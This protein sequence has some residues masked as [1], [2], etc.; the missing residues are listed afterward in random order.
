MTED[1]FLK[2]H[3]LPLMLPG[4]V[5]IA[6]LIVSDWTPDRRIEYAR[7]R[8]QTIAEKSDVLMFGSKKNGE[9]GQLIA[10]LAKVVACLSFQ[11]GGVTL[12]G[13][14]WQADPGPGDTGLGPS[15]VA[16]F[17]LADLFT[18][19]DDPPPTALPQEP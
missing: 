6:I 8:A 15:P 1:A 19:T 11:P 2:N 3:S 16:E 7:S 13:H 9:A 12:F 4:L 18:F 5:E 17:A 14:L 10:E